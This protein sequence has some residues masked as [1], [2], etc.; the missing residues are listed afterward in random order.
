M[1]ILCL[2]SST[3]NY[4][5][6]DVFASMIFLSE[7]LVNIYD[8]FFIFILFPSAINGRGNL[9]LKHSVPYFFR[10]FSKHC[11]LNCGRL[12]DRLTDRQKLTAYLIE[13]ANLGTYW[14]LLVL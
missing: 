1:F 4:N 7:K 13:R 14:I 11:V 10:Q 12:T 6:E 5:G 3:L 8:F 9:E 2:F